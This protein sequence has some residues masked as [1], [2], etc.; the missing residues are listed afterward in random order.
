MYRTFSVSRC[1]VLGQSSVL[2]AGTFFPSARTE[3]SGRLRVP[4]IHPSRCYAPVRTLAGGRF[5]AARNI[6][7]KT[8]DSRST[9]QSPEE[10]HRFSSSPRHPLRVAVGGPA[11]YSYGLR[12]GGRSEPRFYGGPPANPPRSRA[13]RGSSHLLRAVAGK[14]GEVGNN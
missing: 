9:H 6:G 1:S 4:S 11:F 2:T 8:H 7:R 10:K 5:A 12:V 14:S 13:P 3:I